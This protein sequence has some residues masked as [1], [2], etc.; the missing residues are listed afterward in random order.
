MREHKASEIECRHSEIA[1]NSGIKVIGDQWKYI[2][3]FGR[4][5]MMMMTFCTLESP[6][7]NASFN[8]NWS[9]VKCLAALVICFGHQYQCEWMT[10]AIGWCHKS[11]A[12]NTFC[13]Y[14]RNGSAIKWLR[15]WV[16]YIRILDVYRWKYIITCQPH[17]SEKSIVTT[18]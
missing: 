10:V 9:Q 4:P 6:C 16:Q 15:H 3:M 12:K 7:V 2:Y 11:M 18:T 1:I 5:M 8:A 13:R 17:E 14:Y